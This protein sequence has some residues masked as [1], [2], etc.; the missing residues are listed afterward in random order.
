MQWRLDFEEE[1]RNGVSKQD[2]ATA[3]QDVGK[4]LMCPQK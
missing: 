3:E 2:L 4:L 1:Q